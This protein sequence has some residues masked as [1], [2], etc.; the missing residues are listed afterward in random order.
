MSG[1]ERDVNKG[2]DRSDFQDSGK[3]SNADCYL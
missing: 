2:S 3:F 1:N